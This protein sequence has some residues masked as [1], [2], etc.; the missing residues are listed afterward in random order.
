MVIRLTQV[1][2]EVKLRAVKFRAQNGIEASNSRFYEHY[3]GW[4]TLLIRSI[5]FS[6]VGYTCPCCGMGRKEDKGAQGEI[7]CMAK[8]G[9]N[10]QRS[11]V[12]I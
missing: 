12:L 10:Y 2:L 9:Y 3:L 4:E 5:D 1:L 6:M 8:F 7:I 11:L